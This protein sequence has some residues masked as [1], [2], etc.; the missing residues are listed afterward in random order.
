MNVIYRL[1]IDL[2]KQVSLDFYKNS[3]Y[4]ITCSFN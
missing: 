4:I 1:D 2:G 3:D